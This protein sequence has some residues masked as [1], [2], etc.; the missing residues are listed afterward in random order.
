MEFRWD[1]HKR[2]INLRKH[3]IEL[4]DAVRVFDDP[5]ALTLED[6]DHDEQRFVTMGRDALGRVLVVAY[7][8]QEP[9][10][11]RLISARKAEPHERRQYEG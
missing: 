9:D 5:L 8:Y 6:C 10:T 3:R 7:A 1:E 4:A 2:Q 11:L